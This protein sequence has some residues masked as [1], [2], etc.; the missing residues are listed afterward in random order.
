MIQGGNGCVKPV[1]G[2]AQAPPFLFARGI[3]FE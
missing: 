1:L 2:L 3:G